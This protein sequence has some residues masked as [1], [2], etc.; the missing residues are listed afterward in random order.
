MIRRTKKVVRKQEEITGKRDVKARRNINNV[1]LL[2]GGGRSKN[3]ITFPMQNPSKEACAINRKA[4][5]TIERLAKEKIKTYNDY[6]KM[7]QQDKCNTRRG[8]ECSKIKQNIKYHQKKANK[9]LFAANNAVKAYNKDLKKYP[10]YCPG[11]KESFY[12]LQ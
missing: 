11:K 1:L 10:Q 4:L 3:G 9:L 8:K 7:Y 6:V 5:K 2:S 12:N